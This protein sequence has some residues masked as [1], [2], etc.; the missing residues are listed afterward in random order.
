MAHFISPPHSSSGNVSISGILVDLRHNF[1][2]ART[3]LLCNSILQP[4]STSG[5]RGALNCLT[6][7]AA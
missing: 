7:L 4:P 5:P 6:G 2:A 1:L 3:E